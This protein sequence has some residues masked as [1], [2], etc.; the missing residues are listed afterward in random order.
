MNHPYA[1]VYLSEIAETQGRMFEKMQDD[2]P[3]TDGVAFVKSYMNS[4]TR[5]HL[6]SGDAYLANLSATELRNYFLTQDKQVMQNGRPLYGFMPN[7]IGQFY[8]QYQWERNISSKEAVREVPV[9]WLA[10]AYYGLHDLDLKLA[11]E[12]VSHLK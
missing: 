10:N 5:E 12:K 6:D 9:E 2:F 7:W 1:E 11:V 3:T 4:T 8:A